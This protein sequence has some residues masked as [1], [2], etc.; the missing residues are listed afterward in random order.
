MKLRTYIKNSDL[1]CTFAQSSKQHSQEFCDILSSVKLRVRK[2][3]GERKCCSMV[4]W[5]W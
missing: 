1:M 4:T 5:R 3:A 2:K